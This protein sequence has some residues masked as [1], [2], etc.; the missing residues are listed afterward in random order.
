MRRG[1]DS[2]HSLGPYRRWSAAGV[3][4]Q[5]RLGILSERRRGPG[6]AHPAGSPAHWASLIAFRSRREWRGTTAL[7]LDASGRFFRSFLPGDTIHG[8]KN[9]LISPFRACS[10]GTVDATQWPGSSKG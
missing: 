6:S 7:S 3:A 10:I 4:L 2:R 8:T 5:L 1:P 9:S